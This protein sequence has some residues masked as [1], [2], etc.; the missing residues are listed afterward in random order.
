VL[1]PCEWSLILDLTY[2][3]V[4]TLN[5]DGTLRIDNVQP[6]YTIVAKSIWV[7]GGT[8]VA[9]TSS[10]AYTKNLEIILEGNRDSNYL[11]I[12]DI[13]DAGN[14]ILAVTSRLELYGLSPATKFTRLV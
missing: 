9:G 1:I 8:L 6:K 10:D 7:R 5:I 11:I 12:D 3:K 4:N 14:K 13:V 2:I